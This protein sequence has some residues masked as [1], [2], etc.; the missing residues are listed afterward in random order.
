MMN[1][2]RKVGTRDISRTK[3][4]GEGVERFCNDITI[5]KAIVKLGLDNGL[6]RN[7]TKTRGS[8]EDRM[9]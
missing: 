1:F 6:I 3:F 9:I 2:L 5:Y 4:F 7:F 8:D